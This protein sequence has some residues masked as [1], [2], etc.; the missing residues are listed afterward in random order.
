M[1]KDDEHRVRLDCYIPKSMKFQ[2]DDKKKGT[3]V[4]VD[5]NEVC[6]Y[7]TMF[8]AGLKLPFPKVIRELLGRLNVAPHQLVPNA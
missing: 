4:R 8:R 3:I 1:T 5:E 2:F 6:L 7:E